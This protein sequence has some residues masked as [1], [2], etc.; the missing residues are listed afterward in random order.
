MTAENEKLRTWAI[1]GTLEKN[2]H[3]FRPKAMTI[4]QGGPQRKTSVSLLTATAL[5]TG[6]EISTSDNLI[7]QKLSLGANDILRATPLATTPKLCQVG[8]DDLSYIEPSMCITGSPP[9]GVRMQTSL[10]SKRGYGVSFG[11][12]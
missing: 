5:S 10:L 2:Q 3:A 6:T 9:R 4:G 12:R 1:L 11:L 7:G 8:S